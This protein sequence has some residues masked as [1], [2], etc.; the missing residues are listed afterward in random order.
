MELWVDCPDAAM[1]RAHARAGERQT[2]PLGESSRMPP[3]RQLATRRVG[4]RFYRS[5]YRVT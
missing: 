5:A 4:C 3:P 2:A 1:P